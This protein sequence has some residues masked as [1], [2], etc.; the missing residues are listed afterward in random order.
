VSHAYLFDVAPKMALS[1][2]SFIFN[3]NTYMNAIIQVDRLSKN[4]KDI[5]AVEDLSF[6]VNECD[7]YG[8][9]GQN[10]AGKSTV[11]R[12]LMGLIK[13]TKGSIK[14]FGMD[15]QNNRE[16]IMH[17]VG[18][19]IEK[20]DVYKYLTGLENLELFSKISGGP[21]LTHQSFM[22]KLELVG[23]E[24][25]ANSKVSTYSQ[26]MKQRLG[27]AIALVHNPPLI[28]LDEP[29]NGLDPQGIAD[30]RNLISQL[31]NEYKKT[32]IISSHLLSEIELVATRIL[33]IDKGKKVVEGEASELFDP[34][35]TIVDLQTTDNH[36]ALFKLEQS[37]W[38]PA[39]QPKRRHHIILRMNRNE[40]PKLNQWLVLSG[41]E[42]I[43]LQPRHSLEDYFLQVTTANQHVEPFAD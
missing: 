18:A 31:R 23:L 39:L 16:K 10:G 20:P 24:V 35:Q 43:S 30:V 33:I 36:V 1:S 41:I 21:Q 9:L 17:N 38:A 22:E 5:V 13:P 29:T 19:V 28:I 6:T 7:V 3:C 2:T 32:I 25:R 27:I 14:L 4:F 34:A 40:I 8:F 42:V 11:I 26:G 12:M 15:L 37:K